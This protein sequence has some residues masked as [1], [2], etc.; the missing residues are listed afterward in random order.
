MERRESFK[1]KN[2]NSWLV[3][4][5]TLK[6]PAKKMAMCDWLTEHRAALRQ[7]GRSGG[8]DQPAANWVTV[9]SDQLNEGG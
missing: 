8:R 1:E 2:G 4:R 3:A 5:A 6:Q 9:A 7:A